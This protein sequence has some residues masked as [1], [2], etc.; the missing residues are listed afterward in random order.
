VALW[1]KVRRARGEILFVPEA[2][3]EHAWSTSTGQRSALK[4]Y[5]VERNRLWLARALHGDLRAAGLLA[6]TAL[7]YAAYL[8]AA[9]R[10]Q[11]PDPALRGA[12]ARAVRD[13]LLRPLPP[14]VVDYLACPDPAPLAPYLAPMREQLRNPLA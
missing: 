14:D 2:H 3:A 9:P 8:A 12:L 10:A 7:R 13:G 6:F 5:H 11:A 1:V 4:L